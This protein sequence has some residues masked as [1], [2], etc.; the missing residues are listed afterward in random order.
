[1][2]DGQKTELWESD[3][4]RGHMRLSR[5][6]VRED[7]NDLIRFGHNTMDT[8]VP[9]ER[10][11]DNVN[12]NLCAHSESELIDPYKVSMGLFNTEA[13]PD[14]ITEAWHNVRCVLVWK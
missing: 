5:L 12:R 1:M 2:R 3:V 4:P 14:Q 11:P 7:P 8:L 10:D 13:A 9:P 6:R